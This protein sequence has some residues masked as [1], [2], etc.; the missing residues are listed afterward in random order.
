M[1]TYLRILK[2]YGVLVEDNEGWVE[3]LQR[4]P[5]RKENET[6]KQWKIRMFGEDVEGLRI[7]APYEPAPQTRMSTLYNDSGA[8]YLL[9]AL[10]DYRGMAEEEAEEALEAAVENTT[11]EITKKLT[12]VPKNVLKE[13][14]IENEDYLEPSALEFLN[15][16]IEQSGRNVNT[17][18]ILTDLITTY[19]KVVAQYRAKT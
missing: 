6:F 4:V 17:K 13:I 19:S 12:T 14:V 3:E 16:Y 7:Y 9:L 1:S 5:H 18:E 11:E 10:E 8:D 15:R 2:K